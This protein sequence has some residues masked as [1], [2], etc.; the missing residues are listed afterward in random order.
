AEHLLQIAPEILHVRFAD[1]LL[2]VHDLELL[3]RLIDVARELRDPAALVHLSAQLELELPA[4]R[5]LAPDLERADLGQPGPHPHRRRASRRLLAS[6]DRRAARAS[7]RRRCRE[8]R[9]REARPRS[10]RAPSETPLRAS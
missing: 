4:V 6:I 8:L 5:A 9:R 7:R 2:A 3:A 10:A 1:R